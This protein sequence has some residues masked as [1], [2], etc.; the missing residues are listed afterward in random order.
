V[1]A[2]EDKQDRRSIVSDTLQKLE[3]KAR[4][5]RS[6][7]DLLEAGQQVD[8]SA[9]AAELTQL[10]DLSQNLRDA[11]LSEDSAAQ[12]RSKEELH[13]LVTRLDD[14][15]D[16][17]QV[18]L[19][20]VQRLE[21][22]TVI[23]R[24]ERTR[25][26]RLRER[27]AAVAELLEISAQPVVP[28]LPGPEASGWL[29]W[30]CSLDDSSHDPDL[31]LLKMFF[32]R[33]DD[34]VRQ[35]EIEMWRDGAAEPKKDAKKEKEAKPEGIHVVPVLQPVTVGDVATAEADAE[36]EP[37][38]VF[39]EPAE[40]IEEPQKPLTA[41]QRG[42]LL[43]EEVDTQAAFLASARREPKAARGVRALVAVSHWLTPWDQNPLL[44]PGG[45][46]AAEIRYMGASALQ[47]V[48]A[49]QAEQA[50]KATEDLLL[51]TG[52]ADLL[53]WSLEHADV[54]RADAV[55][56]VRRLSEAQVKMWFNQ[57]F[58]IE[59]AVPQVKDMYRLTRGIPLLMGELHRR[60][61]PLHDT[62][63]TWLGF[64]IWT[65]VQETFESQIPVLA[66]ELKDGAPAVRLTERE[67]AILKMVV[68]ASD[69]STEE[70]LAANLMENWHSYGQPDV[71]PLSSADENSVRVLE[72][73]GL[74]PVRSEAIARPVKALLP[75]EADDPIRQL[76]SLL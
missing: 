16:K 38:D 43:A 55:A 5:M 8:R 47:P 11:V 63:P 34:F 36:E 14:L 49:E 4:L 44:Y 66:Q 60:V 67:L 39:I 20:L 68:T 9:V 70:T 41:V 28:A 12:W 71:A 74:V 18:Y 17:R 61:I 1:N 13:A 15:A 37:L 32:P 26:E 46:I 73:L 42:F 10:L 19:D 25:E 51:V 30:A 53:R 52:G 35:L 72:M 57:V 7:I 56:S 31:K 23:H 65:R 40:E 6:K 48:T 54:D 3:E 22:G 21:L 58:K 45:G 27:D 2:I 59:L 75:L 29:E 62:P 50:I 64:A 24:R 33:L 69:N 76:V